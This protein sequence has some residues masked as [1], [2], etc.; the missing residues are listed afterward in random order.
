MGKRRGRGV[1]AVGRSKRDDQFLPIPY[2]MAH[3]P[4]FRSLGGPALKVW[5]E[6][7]SRFN[8][9]NNGKLSLSLGDAAKLL[10]LSKTTAKRAFDE[11][12]EKGFLRLRVLGHW[13][14]RRAS[15]FILTDV[16]FGDV[17]PTRDWEQW[18]PDPPKKTER[19][20]LAEHNERDGT[21]RE[22]AAAG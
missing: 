2:A 22:P 20:I 4:A 5:I 7:R 10:H 19:G 6:I 12:Q 9:F 8:G 16:R 15:E 17:P 18:R 14:G 1:N 13:Y 21:D 11:L 3:S